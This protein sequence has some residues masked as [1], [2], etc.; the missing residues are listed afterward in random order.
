MTTKNTTAN[1]A[2][3]QG[4]APNAVHP[5]D[6]LDSDRP[7]GCGAPEDVL[8]E[9][10][11][12]VLGPSDEEILAEV[13]KSGADPEEYAERTRKV[14]RR[15]LQKFD[16]VNRRLQE[17]GHAIDDWEALDGSYDSKC[18]NCGLSVSF[19]ATSNEIRGKASVTPCQARDE[20]TSQRR[21]AA[22]TVTDALL[23]GQQ[24]QS[25]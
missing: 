4:G 13:R 6:A 23:L 2:D 8:D 22:R 16:N 5:T 12:S 11:D 1:V 7:F 24:S 20:N 19:F 18:K 15:A 10:A 21:E 14:L 9:L 3:D 17:L 25:G